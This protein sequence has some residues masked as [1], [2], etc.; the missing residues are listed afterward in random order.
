MTGVT[1]RTEDVKP[2]PRRGRDVES[3]NTKK[4]KVIQKVM[5]KRCK[6]VAFII[7]RSRVFFCLCCF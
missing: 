5:A 4:V 7:L 2:L 3:G 1:S 6:F